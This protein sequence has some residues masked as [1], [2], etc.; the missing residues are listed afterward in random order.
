MTDLAS[1][2]DDLEALNALW[3]K[4]CVPVLSEQ[5]Q[6]RVGNVMRNPLTADS[7]YAQEFLKGECVGLE[8]ASGL[9][10]VLLEEAKRDLE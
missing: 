3:L 10:Q 2:I 8:M 9:P 4:Y 6:E 7:V 5:V 1:K